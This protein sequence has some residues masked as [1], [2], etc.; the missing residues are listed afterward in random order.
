MY[1]KKGAFKVLI[2]HIVYIHK[3]FALQGEITNE[4]VRQ[5][6]ILIDCLIIVC[7][8]FDNILAIIKY[9]YKSNLIAILTHVFHQVS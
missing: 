7:R 8:H 2:I 9:E 6:A 5:I 1:L 3:S 4:M